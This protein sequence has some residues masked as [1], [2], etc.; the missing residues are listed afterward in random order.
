MLYL[1]R[2]HVRF[3]TASQPAST[4]CGV[5]LFEGFVWRRRTAERKRNYS[6]ADVFLRF[7]H[8]FV[9]TFVFRTNDERAKEVNAILHGSFDVSAP[10]KSSDSYR[11]I[12][13]MGDLT[14][15]VLISVRTQRVY[16]KTMHGGSPPSE[17][18]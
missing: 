7:L 8:T 9:V 4:L 3:W 6:A 12:V 18:K 1:R 13:L 2:A 10:I 15:R 14:V 5:C 17:C 16:S 11:F